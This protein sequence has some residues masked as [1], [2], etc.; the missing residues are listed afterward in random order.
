MGS[1]EKVQAAAATL[2]LAARDR[3]ARGLVAGRLVSV[4]ISWTQRQAHVLVHGWLQPP[5]DLGLEMHR[6]D[7]ALGF[8]NAVATGSDDLD[9]EFS[10][11]ADDPSRTGDLFTVALREHLVA[12]HRAS[13][14]VR[15]HDG[16]CTLSEPYSFGMDEAWI[17]RAAH[18]A[19]QI[20]ELLDGARA[21]LRAAASLAGHAEALRA[22]A[23]AR[24]LAFASAPLSVTGRIEGGPIEIGSER[25]ARDRHRVIARASFETELGLG[26]AVR[27]ERLLDGLVTMLGGQD[28]V[29][30]D[31]AFDR[32]FLV[33]VDP[34]QTDRAPELLDPGAR[35]ALLALDDRAGPV[36][37]DD[38]GVTVGPIASSIAPETM[39]WAIDTLDE[40]RARV[41]RNLLRGTGGGPYR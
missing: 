24:G 40:V 17:V 19:A 38:R 28:I 33:R 9:S 5:L 37:I 23:A 29:V 3:E 39:V 30:D 6:R 34:R 36:A 21:G 18:S 20:V 8:V 10:I 25:A 16:G 26:L 22:L 41:Q 14:D 32:R 2:G 31:E 15:I 1:W 11:A 4:E 35:R 27:R 13:Y 12:L 7:V